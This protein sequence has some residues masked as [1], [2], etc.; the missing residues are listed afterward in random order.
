MS[1]RSIR[2]LSPVVSSSGPSE[3]DP[4]W[5][6]ISIVERGIFDHVYAQS[7]NISTNSKSPNC[8]EVE[9]SLDRIDELKIR[10]S[11]SASRH[12]T[13]FQPTPAENTGA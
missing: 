3:L 5:S 7:A 10:L 2:S 13:R 9:R 6:E 1:M 4:N 8:Y 11:R 12:R